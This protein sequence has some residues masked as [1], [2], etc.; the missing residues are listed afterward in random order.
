M[1]QTTLETT[2]LGKSEGHLEAA[3]S[4]PLTASG[5]CWRPHPGVLHQWFASEMPIPLGGSGPTNG[6]AGSPSPKHPPNQHTRTTGPK[7]FGSSEYGVF[8][9]LINT[10]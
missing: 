2:E 3:A 7:G 10:I 5:H 6:M 1:P 8:P 4:D 9:G